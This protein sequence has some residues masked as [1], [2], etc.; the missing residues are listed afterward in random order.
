MTITKFLFW[1]LRHFIPLYKNKIYDV[2]FS[3]CYCFL[4]TIVII[5]SHKHNESCLWLSIN[6]WFGLSGS[7]YTISNKNMEIHKNVVS[8]SNITLRCWVIHSQYPN[9]FIDV[10][11]FINFYHSFQNKCFD[12]IEWWNYINYQERW[13]V[14]LGCLDKINQIYIY[15]IIFVL[16]GHTIWIYNT[17]FYVKIL[18]HDAVYFVSLGWIDNAVSWSWSPTDEQ[19]AFS[20]IS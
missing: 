4:S 17:L 7:C 11:D 19:R 14:H 15:H 12:L 3:G 8:I 2:F 20:F 1:L 18:L 5:I 6:Y 16:S 13:G 10:F 9:N